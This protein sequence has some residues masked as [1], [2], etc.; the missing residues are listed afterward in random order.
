MPRPEQRG[1]TKR[2]KAHTGK[3]GGE[4]VDG[5]R[6]EGGAFAPGNSL[7]KG[8]GERISKGMQLRNAL[9]DQVG[10][11]RVRKLVDDLYE[12]ATGTHQDEGPHLRD[13][14]TARILGRQTR[15]GSRGRSRVRRAGQ[16][17]NHVRS[18]GRRR[19]RSA[20]TVTRLR[21]AALCFATNAATRRCASAR[22]AWCR[23]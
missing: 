22:A 11:K 19:W 10:E 15:T 3:H 4:I 23:G 21:S 1:K 18:Q 17:T 20:R 12:I 2:A 8:Q 7:A 6:C 9:R 13:Q 16:Y 5:Q 14:D